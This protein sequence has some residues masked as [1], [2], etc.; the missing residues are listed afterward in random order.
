MQGVTE[1][2]GGV[3]ELEAGNMEAEEGVTEAEGGVPKP[4]A[5]NM[6]AKEG[7]TEVE[8]GITEAEAR[9]MEAE[10]G[11]TEADGGVM[12]ADLEEATEAEEGVTEPHLEKAADREGGVTEAKEVTQEMEY[13][14]ANRRNSKRRGSIDEADKR[15]TRSRAGVRWNI[16][17]R[18]T[19]KRVVNVAR[20]EHKRARK[21]A[22]WK[23]SDVCRSTAEREQLE[24]NRRIA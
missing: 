5:G 22:K 21:E 2:E 11:V 9:N 19:W 4:K 14:L 24:Q 12:E 13:E 7:V 20:N 10:G 17:E 1:A 3:M 23:W 15:G 8:G 6:E 16:R 18:D